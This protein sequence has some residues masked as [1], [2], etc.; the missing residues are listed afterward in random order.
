MKNTSLLLSLFTLVTCAADTYTP[1]LPGTLRGWTVTGA[2]ATS[3]AASAPLA[4]PAGSQLSR[5]FGGN[6][7]I[8]RS[9]SLPVFSSTA[10]SWPLLEVGP[11]SLVML[12]RQ[13]AG[14]LIIVVGGEQVADLTDSAPLAEAS[15]TPVELMLGFDPATS[16]VVV[17][18]DGRLEAYACPAATSNVEVALTAGDT[19][20]WPQVSLEV[21]VL[22]SGASAPPGFSS[23][24]VH[25]DA[26]TAAAARLESAINRWQA[27]GPEALTA[28]PAQAAPA[29]S[30][31][32]ASAV[33][34]EIF[35][36]Q[37][38]RHAHVSA[39]RATVLQRQN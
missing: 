11:A 2:K 4:L 31:I 7:V 3:V 18:W 20:A 15:A 39:I 22:G 19:S 16:T 1:V 38:V 8:V 12:R 27:G 32:A 6:A 26:A 9:I 5:A 13:D 21:L 37:A 10:E 33:T 24:S 14:H 35:T 30:A 29:A 36:P 25:R 34:L 23:G 17:G 28:S